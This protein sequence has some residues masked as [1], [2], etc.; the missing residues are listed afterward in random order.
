[1]TLRTLALVLATSVVAFG[2]KREMKAEPAPMPADEKSDK[3][4]G[5]DK[6]EEGSEEWTPKPIGGGPAGESEP[7]PQAAPPTPG[8][9]PAKPKATTPKTPA[10]QPSA[11][12]PTPAPSGWPWLPPATPTWPWSVSDGGSTAPAPSTSPSPSP[13]AVPPTWPFPWPG[14]TTDKPTQ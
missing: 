13:S 9:A 10:P 3:S 2:C 14:A 8:A 4:E 11:S 5:P 12:A 6:D 1:M 7:T